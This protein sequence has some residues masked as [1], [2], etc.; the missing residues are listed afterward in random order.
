MPLPPRFTS[1]GCFHL[2]SIYGRYLYLR[3]HCNPSPMRQHGTE[4]IYGNRI[5]YTMS[6][7]CGD[8]STYTQRFAHEP[9]KALHRMQDL[10]TDNLSS[11][12]C[13]AEDW[14][15][16]IPRSTVSSEPRCPY[17]DHRFECRFPSPLIHPL[18]EETNVPAVPCLLPCC[19]HSHSPDNV[20][21]RPLPIPIPKRV[22]CHRRVS[23]E[24]MTPLKD[25]E[26]DAAQDGT[27]PVKQSKYMAYPWAFLLTGP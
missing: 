8:N 17:I 5:K 3:Y 9:S 12:E 14:E 25:Y 2:P 15:L 22:R 19:A 6:S 13:H 23:S 1:G 4:Q 10:L 7:K 24:I 20:K 11:I 16:P 18:D 27:G 26:F 21:E